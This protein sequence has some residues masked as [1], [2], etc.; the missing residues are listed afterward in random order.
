LPDTRLVF[1]ERERVFNRHIENIG[2][3]QAA[4]ARSMCRSSIRNAR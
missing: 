4:P 3:A 1:E 2:D